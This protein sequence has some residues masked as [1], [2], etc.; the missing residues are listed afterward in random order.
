MYCKFFSPVLLPQLLLASSL[1]G[2]GRDRAKVWS[3]LR[4][5]L[6]PSWQPT[7]RFLRWC[8]AYYFHFLLHFSCE[9]SAGERCQINSPEEWRALSILRTGTSPLSP[10][11]G[12]SRASFLQTA[13][14][15]YLNPD[16]G[17]L[18]CKGEKELQSPLSIKS[19][20]SMPAKGVVSYAVDTCP[21]GSGLTPTKLICSLQSL[22]GDF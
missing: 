6:S 16:I 15:R 3:S 18:T 5:L 10:P 12:C 11:P 9:Y 13:P 14:S 7:R 20:V 2:G 17:G 1:S 8:I 21:L 4:L 22:N 19:L